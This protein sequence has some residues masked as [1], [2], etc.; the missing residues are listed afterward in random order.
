MVN[1]S[2]V[3]GLPATGVPAAHV[4]AKHAVIGLTKEAAAEYGHLGI[5]VNALAVSSTMTDMIRAAPAVEPGLGDAF[6]SNS[7]QRCWAEP[8][9]VAAAAAWLCS[10]RSSSITGSAMAV[11][12]GATAI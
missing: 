11:D 9:E 12:G 7:I 2:S 8:V 6:I 3:A 1:A 5:R 4:A 10:G